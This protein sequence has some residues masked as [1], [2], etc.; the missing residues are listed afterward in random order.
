M[1]TTQTG[2]IA[3]VE[4]KSSWRKSDTMWML[5]LYG[6]AIGAGVLFLP[7]NAG[8]GG[9]IPLFI[10]AIL[11][12]PMTFFAHRG[13]TR[14]VLSGKN[15]GEDITEVV[16]EHFGV[17]A[18]KVITLLYFFAIYPI[19]LVYSV[20]ITNT[21]D[22]FITHQLGMVSPPRALLSLILIVGLMTIVRFGE[23]MIVKAMSILVFPF[24]AAL[25]ALALYLIP[26]WSSA[27]FD[28]LSFSAA[29]S[30][31]TGS[32]LWMTL[33]LAIPVMVFS[34]NHSPI[35][36]AFAVAKR[37]EYGDEAEK[38]CSRIL[39]FAH[40]M[41]VI[42]VMFFVFSCVLSLSPENLAEAKAQNISILSYLANH[43]NA[44]VIAWMAPIIAIV[45]ITK[46][47]LGHY[48]GAREG[49]NGMVIKSLRGKGKTIE[50]SKLNRITAIFMLVTTWIV[51]TLNP[52]ILGMIETL[53][54]PIIAMI[55]FLMPMYAIQK[56][57][58]MRK[59][60]GH[61]SNVF[62]VIMGLVAISAISYSLYS[63]FI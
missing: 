47:F 9:L 14:F 19:L 42:T 50:I 34:F 16:E 3:S 63:L 49:F 11:A 28:T 58:A 17:G 33:W 1:E 4:S 24:V 46:S 62:V 7:I 43:F 38:K 39:S 25:M 18:G 10:M 20:A 60:S 56:V 13:L 5:G 8:V 52:S 61:I 2:S 36:S 12:F 55:L 45:A 44:P 37:N 21:V 51:A 40:I 59:Y 57:P 35:I 22:S 41:M 32:G 53:G 29:A 26:E 48:L 54:G 31:A 6:T 27:A 15:P 30:P 23:Q